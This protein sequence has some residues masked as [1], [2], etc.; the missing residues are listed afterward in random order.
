MLLLAKDTV[1]DKGNACLAAASAHIAVQMEG[2][3]RVAF[4]DG[5]V[6]A[7]PI[8]GSGEG[9][10]VYRIRSWVCRGCRRFSQ[11]MQTMF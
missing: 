2:R 7:K 9:G 8:S 3:V 4:K 10:K 6:V 5:I 11:T 1:K